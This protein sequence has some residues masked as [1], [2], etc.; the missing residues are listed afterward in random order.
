[1]FHGYGIIQV[2]QKMLLKGVDLIKISLPY[3]GTSNSK[4]K[5]NLTQRVTSSLVVFIELFASVCECCYLV[6]QSSPSPQI[7]A[8]SP[9]GWALARA[10]LRAR[11]SCWGPWASR[12]P[13]SCP[14]KGRK[15][16]S[17][18]R[19]C[20]LLLRCLLPMQT[21]AKSL[22]VRPVTLF[23][24]WGTI[25]SKINGTPKGVYLPISKLHSILAVANLLAYNNV[26]QICYCGQI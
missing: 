5:L 14:S 16:T 9:S 7:Q 22:K 13:A 19:R 11:W 17:L 6:W 20:S 18:P 12:P 23:T 21:S 10:M 25:A 15:R 3:L 4:L 26:S 8:A 1:M 2:S 24:L